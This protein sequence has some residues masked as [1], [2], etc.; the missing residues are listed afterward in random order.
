[1]TARPVELARYTQANGAPIV[2]MQLGRQYRVCV[3][4][5]EREDDHPTRWV[6]N[7]VEDTGYDTLAEAQAYARTAAGR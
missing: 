5:L 1:M 4:G 6:E 7:V 2:V 3:W